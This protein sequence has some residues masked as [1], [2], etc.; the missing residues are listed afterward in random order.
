[1]TY[2]SLLKTLQERD[3]LLASELKKVEQVQKMSV[4]E[5]LLQLLGKYLC[6]INLT[7][8]KSLRCKI[9]QY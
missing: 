5:S 6:K 1:M 8:K 7:I 3:K 2:Q 4:T 9:F